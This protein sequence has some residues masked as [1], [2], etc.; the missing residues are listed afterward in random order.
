MVERPK[1]SE[2]NDQEVSL[3]SYFATFGDRIELRR[4]PRGYRARAFHPAMPDDVIY[5]KWAKSL[6]EWRKYRDTSEEHPDYSLYSDPEV[7]GTPY[8]LT[9]E[10]YDETPMLFTGS[11][12]KILWH[13]FL[14]TKT[15]LRNPLQQSPEHLIEFV[16]E[17]IPEE[18]LIE[19]LRKKI[20]NAR[21]ITG[22]RKPIPQAAQ[23]R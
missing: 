23:G 2:Q 20:P 18:V 11:I 1:A 10:T 9:P 15:D 22:W 4:V 14:L 12:K 13:T 19:R 8:Y 17:N 21:T 3:D 6:G 5:L 16:R 7:P